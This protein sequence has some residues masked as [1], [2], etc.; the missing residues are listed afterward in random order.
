MPRNVTEYRCLLISPSDVADERDAL[1]ATIERWNAQVGDALGT[2]VN[3]VR[4]ETHSVP[5]MSGDPQTVLNDQIVDDCDLGIALFWSRLGTPT[6]THASGSIEEIYR[7]LERGVRVMVYFKSSAIPQAQISFN[8]LERLRQIKK[9]FMQKGVLG[10]FDNVDDLKEQVLLH[11]TSTVSAMLTRARTTEP[12]SVGGTADI[13][14]KPSIRVRV[15]PGIASDLIRGTVD[16]LGVNVE[17]HSPTPVFLGNIAILTND[18][19]MLIPRHD[20]LTRQPQIRRTLNPGQRFTLNL[21]LD[22]LLAA[23]VNVSQLDRASVVDD[24]GRTYESD[25]EEFRKVIETLLAA[26]EDHG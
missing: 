25:P 13:L 15:Q 7:L 2:R 26:A 10:S 11:L 16:V 8:Q 23:D 22:D 12:H 1:A 5:D 6:G 20:S 3:L 19:R 9:E 14:Q 17:N 4:W 18:A 24:I 21:T